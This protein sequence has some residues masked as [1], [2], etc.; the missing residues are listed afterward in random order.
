MHHIGTNL[1]LRTES[2]R[3]R[4]ERHG[5]ETL[6]AIARVVTP[7]QIARAL[8]EALS[9]TIKTKT[10]EIPDYRT[11]LE[12]AKVFM[13]YTIGLP[14]E[15]QPEPEPVR[16]PESSSASLNR[17]MAS[18]AARAALRRM[19]DEAEENQTKPTIEMAP[20]HVAATD[21]ESG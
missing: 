6:S 17:I 3:Q 18:P 13:N 8:A 21:S 5:A 19:L 14:V 7:E 4:K 11:R 20:E 9:A 12:A 10:G 16:T 2:A 1:V 15:R